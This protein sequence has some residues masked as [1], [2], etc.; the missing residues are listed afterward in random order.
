MCY[1][2]LIGISVE[3]FKK[4]LFNMKKEKDSPI[5][6]K[7][8][9]INKSI[10]NNE[11]IICVDLTVASQTDVLPK[12]A[13]LVSPVQQENEIL[14]VTNSLN[15]D[16]IRSLETNT[17]PEKGTK[18]ITTKRS[19]KAQ[20]EIL[21]EKEY[22]ENLLTTQTAKKPKI[23]TLTSKFTKAQ[24]EEQLLEAQL[25]N[26]RLMSQISGKG[27]PNN[28]VN[29]L[30][31][32][33]NQNT[34]PNATLN[35]NASPYVSY[36]S[37]NY[38]PTNFVNGVNYLL[39]QKSSPGIA[40]SQNTNTGLTFSQNINPDLT[41][42]QNINPALA[43]SQNTNTGL[44][45]SQNINPGL[46]L[47]QNASPGVALRQN[48]NPGLTLS[49]NTSPGPTLSQN[50]SPGLTYKPQKSLRLKKTP[51]TKLNKVPFP[52]GNQPNLTNPTNTSSSKIS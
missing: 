35:P 31:F 46:M 18:P 45:L 6:Y 25:L 14:D 19:R 33:L 7:K 49:Q 13:I 27:T 44:T 8:K 9:R 16:N 39:S 50:T 32:L 4:A 47:C 40:L 17:E 11:P 12:D 28:F 34:I 23:S 10:D 15:I 42:C 37:R 29:G 52:L 5:I 30:N 51:K 48:I 21:T 38:V 36:D 3:E 41:V 20:A 1:F 24:L 43:L 26:A 2:S 22:K